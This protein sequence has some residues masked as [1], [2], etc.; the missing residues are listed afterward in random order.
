[1]ELDIVHPRVNQYLH[2]V[3]GPSP[4]VLA[5]MEKIGAERGF[6]IVGPLCGR[7]LQLFALSIGAHRIFEMGSG[8]GYSALW[9]AQAVGPRGR[10]YL[11]DGK[12]ANARQAAGFFKRAGLASRA[13]I[14]VGDAFDALERVDGAFDLIFIDIEK[15]SYPK[16]YKRAR[17]R[18]RRGGILAF[19][20]MLRNGRVVDGD[21]DPAT[22]GVRELT[23]LLHRDR[24]LANVIVPLRD[25]V[26]ISYVME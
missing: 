22:E 25:G 21:D 12:E 9:L 2:R 24:G 15:P 14:F 19:D 6:P 18:L 13:Q 5:E 17:P 7:L 23:R 11:T 1:M 8:Y 16:A 10:V 20:N 26:S 3:A 4:G